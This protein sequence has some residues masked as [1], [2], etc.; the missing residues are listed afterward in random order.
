[1][2]GEP[3]KKTTTGLPSNV[4]ST[5]MLKAHINAKETQLLATSQI[6]ANA[7]HSL[8][9][10]TPR[11]A[12]IRQ[13]L[14]DHLSERVAIGT[15]EIVD[16]NSRPSEQ[17]PQFDIVVYKRDYPKLQL[18]GGICVFF[19]ESV[20]ATI[21]V[22]SKLDNRELEHA[23]RAAQKAKQLTRHISPGFSAGYHPPSILS[24]V[25]AYDGPAS[26]GTV[27]GWISPIYQELGI[28]APQ[29]PTNGD[30]R[31]DTPSPSIDGIFVLGRGFVI[32]DNFPIGFITE[33]QRQQNPTAC[34]LV[35]DTDRGSL[36]LLFM[37][38]TAA[39]SGLS[40]AWL[41]PIPYLSEFNPNYRLA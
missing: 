31:I 38:L 28:T 21:E 22:K 18:G 37:F 12:F 36:L 14:E 9:K 16:S 3:I 33:Q 1:M 20:I 41:D 26:M 29:L 5:F 32:F 4:K 10:G 2:G 25:V 7:G 34:W 15:G 19:A 30:E 13:F 8:H 24:Y 23:M 39:V 6:P 17:R 35:S 11:E 27:Q 40:N